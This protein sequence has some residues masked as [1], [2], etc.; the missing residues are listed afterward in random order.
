MAKKKTRR[1][2][3][4]ETIAQALERAKLVGASQT[5]REMGLGGNCVA[6]WATAAGVT[7]PLFQFIRGRGVIPRGEEGSPRAAPLPQ[8]PR[9][10]P[11]SWSRKSAFSIE[12]RRAIAHETLTEPRSVVA[13]RHGIKA[14]TISNWV[15]RYLDD[16]PSAAPSSAELSNTPIADSAP[17]KRV[18]VRNEVS[19]TPRNREIAQ[20]A[21]Q[22]R[23][24][25]VSTSEVGK[26]FGISGARVSQ[27]LNRMRAKGL[28][29]P[30]NG[31]SMTTMLSRPEPPL[32]TNGARNGRPRAEQ[33][34]LFSETEPQRVQGMPVVDEAELARER[35]Q[36]EL[37]ESALRQ[38]LKERDAFKTVFDVLMREKNQ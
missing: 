6:R 1:S 33:Q 10:G 12:Q 11:K 14:K 13:K 26:R 5:E 23:A 22:A 2:Y 34:P 7:L 25:G 8:S 29:G 19:D 36:S 4:P 27:I 3:S 18:D 28:V 21:Y 35:V 37:M 32:A 30:L 15:E 20:A 31:S 9:S 17:P 38:A 16:S 24:D